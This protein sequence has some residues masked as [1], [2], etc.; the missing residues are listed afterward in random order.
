MFTMQGAPGIVCTTEA[1]SKNLLTE[2]KRAVN[3]VCT[4][5]NLRFNSQNDGRVFYDGDICGL[6]KERKGEG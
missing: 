1:S 3:V 5:Y 4:L 6:T 2:R